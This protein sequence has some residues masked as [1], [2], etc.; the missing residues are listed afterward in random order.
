VP[1]TDNSDTFL[2]EAK[3]V[4]CQAARSINSILPLEGDSDKGVAFYPNRVC[5]QTANRLSFRAMGNSFFVALAYPNF[6]PSKSFQS[7]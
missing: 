7:A 1:C 5:S 3:N 2:G 6:L 4:A